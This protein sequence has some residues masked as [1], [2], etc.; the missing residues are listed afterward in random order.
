LAAPLFA[1]EAVD[2]AELQRIITQHPDWA[3][4][5]ADPEL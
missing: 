2:P 4:W 1:Q 5:L 3:R